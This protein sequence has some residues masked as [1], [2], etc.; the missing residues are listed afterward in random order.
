M[1]IDRLSTHLANLAADIA[2]MAA[3]VDGPITIGNRTCRGNDAPALLAGR[4]ESVPELVLQ[5]RR[6]ELG[7]YRG[8]RFGMVLHPKH[9]PDVYLEGVASRQATLS[10]EFQGPRAILNAVERLAASYESQAAKAQDDLAIARGQLR[11]YEARLGEPFPHAAYQGEL[12][13]LRDRLKVALSGKTP[14]AGA[15]PL[16]S[17]HELADRIREITASQAVEPAPQPR[18]GTR[19]ATAERPVTAR[20]RERREVIPPDSPMEEAA[21]DTEETPTAKPAQVVTRPAAA[22]HP[23]LSPRRLRGRASEDERS[24]ARRSCSS[25]RPRRRHRDDA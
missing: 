25:E 1:T 6:I 23:M 16:P 18:Q 4:L 22:V 19:S 12:A 15:E 10:R 7:L 13:Q 20:I 24:S 3:Q 9:A 21:E 5:A 14:E 11:D 17:A 8:L 2:T